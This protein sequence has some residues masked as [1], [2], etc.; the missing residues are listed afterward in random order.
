MPVTE[1]NPT[2]QEVEK[3][4]KKRH[5]AKYYAATFFLKVGA[6]ALAVWL[7]LTFV[8]GVY[9][10]HEHSAYPMIKDGDLCI[11]YRLAELREG[12]EIAYCRDGAIRFGRITA[13]GGDSVML[14]GDTVT[15][16]GYNL[17]EDVVYATPSEGS[18]ITYPYTVPPNTVFVLNDY[19]SDLTDSRKFGGVPIGDVRGK[20]IFIMRRRG[21]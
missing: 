12:D 2:G 17:F 14:Q 8:A 6:T 16:N 10:C 7:L 13:F 20:V 9:V 18:A 1:G 3:P 11:T 4:H 21:I 19:R 15:V 5:S